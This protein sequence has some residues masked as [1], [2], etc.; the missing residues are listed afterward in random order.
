MSKR[1]LLSTKAGARSPPQSANGEDGTRRRADNLLGD[2]SKEGMG[3]SCPTMGAYHDEIEVPLGCLGIDLAPWPSASNLCRELHAR[4]PNTRRD[5]LERFARVSA[6][7]VGKVW[8]QL[9]NEVRCSVSSLRGIIERMQEGDPGPE[10]AGESN[11]VDQR[12]LR[13]VAEVVRNEDAS[14]RRRRIHPGVTL[15]GADQ[16]LRCSRRAMAH[17]PPEFNAFPA[18]T[19]EV[20]GEHDHG[21]LR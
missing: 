1:P 5:R 7:L 21:L 20:R 19:G 11:G 8:F 14:D 10:C 17:D 15:Q 16:R 12:P 3:D 4:A 6:H 13:R 18:R 2:A 9:T